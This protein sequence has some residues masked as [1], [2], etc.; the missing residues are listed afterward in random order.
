VSVREGANGVC[1]G[2]GGARGGVARR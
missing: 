2:G 1:D